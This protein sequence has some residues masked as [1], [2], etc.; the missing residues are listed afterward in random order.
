MTM[1]GLLKD[2]LLLVLL[3]LLGITL[4][5]W[6]L[7]YGEAASQRAVG[8]LLLVLAFVKV[9]LIISQYMELGKARW[10]VRLALHAW[11]V[12]TVGITLMLYL[13]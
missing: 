9:Q 4:L 10:P 8:G 13:R 3:V 12:L 2:K 1:P 5:S 7:L 11:L 6:L